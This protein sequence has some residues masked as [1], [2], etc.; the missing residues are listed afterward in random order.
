[1]GQLR[2]KRSY[3]ALI[4]FVSILVPS[5]VAFLCYGPPLLKIDG[6]LSFMPKFHAILNSMT[7][8]LL[9]AGYIFI[10]N[11]LILYHRFCMISALTLSLTF[12]LSYVTYHASTEPTE[13][14]GEGMIKTVYYI[15]LITHIIM[16][17]GILPLIL[18]TA[19]RALSG[20]FERHKKI[21]RWTLPLWLYVTI[22]G[23]VVYF[24]IS[25]YY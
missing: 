2:P 9:I 11:K 23:V 24:M 8:V 20:Q 25:P 14:G 19:Y 1:M 21:A 6:D 10:R 16:A 12:L 15:I 7:T 18:F 3:T 17:A 13:Y 22:T 4:I 5:L